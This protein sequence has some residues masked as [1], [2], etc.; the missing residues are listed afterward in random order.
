M[1]TAPQAGAS[2]PLGGAVTGFAKAYKREQSRSLVKAVDFETDLAASE[3]AGA[4]IAETLN[5]PG[6]VEV[7]Y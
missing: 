5:D 4:L 2:A 3:L 7:G 6:V 1:A